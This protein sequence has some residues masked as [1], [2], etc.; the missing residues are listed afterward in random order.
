MALHGHLI[1]MDI[2]TRQARLRFF[3]FVLDSGRAH[4]RVKM[5]VQGIIICVHT[6]HNLTTL[7]LACRSKKT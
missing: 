7:H 2:D 4:L 3:F 1:R 5:R 6:Q